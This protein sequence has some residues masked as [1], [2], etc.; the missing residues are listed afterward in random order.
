MKINTKLL[1]IKLHYFFFMAAVG[2]ILPQ[3]PLFGKDLGISPVVMGTVTGIL[4]FTFLLT[5]P[6]FGL[7]V[8]VWRNQRKTIF[9]LVIIL[10][11]LSFGALY[12]L[13]LPSTVTFY[14]Q[15]SENTHL[16]SCPN[17]TISVV[18]NSSCLT[19]PTNFV[20]SVI[21]P[22]AFKICALPVSELIWSKNSTCEFICT[23]ESD[24]NNSELFTFWSFIM[25]MSVGTI[26][27]NI[28]N[29]IS[30]AICFD[31][32]DD[33]NLYGKQRLWGSIGFGAT[34]LIAGYAV[35]LFSKNHT[36]YA[37]A[38][39][40][41]LICSMFDLLVCFKLKLPVIEAPK[42]IFKDLKVLLTDR[43]V[44]TFIVFTVFVGMLDGVII[45]FLFWY[46]EDLAK[47][48]H[49]TNV[50]LIEGLILAAACLGAE[51]IFFSIS[52]KILKRLGHVHCFTLCFFNYSLRLGLIAL[53]SNPWWVLPIEF[54]LQG[55]TFAL[56]YTVIVAYANEI[57]PAGMSA[58]MQGIAAGM[59]DGTGY[60][61]GSVLGGVLYRFWGGRVTFVAFMA[62]GAA[63]GVLHCVF[64]KTV[65]RCDNGKKAGYEIL[66]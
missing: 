31:V 48:T 45:Y 19:K 32:V 53:V 54:L 58:T 15:F 57:A 20:A 65:L 50:K 64:H 60:A 14:F 18:C 62:F 43:Y 3:L 4:P 66:D 29:S 5:K 33:Q 37:A 46:L 28:V 1:P 22:R 10:M 38:Y 49:T 52:G 63:C 11:T 12:F 35:D 8:D 7:A 6:I 9:V 24:L 23:G 34:G 56:T 36:N 55:P 40:T 44:K 47:E 39:V 21:A 2:P 16:D 27:F 26:G 25:L 17:A 30:D 61:L 41:M 59:G 42:N 13:K 51:V